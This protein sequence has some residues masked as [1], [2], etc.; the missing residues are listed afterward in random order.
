MKTVTAD[1]TGCIF[2]LL[3]GCWFL[4]NSLFLNSPQNTADF[5]PSVFPIISS[6]GIIL[7][8]VYYIVRIIIKK[9]AESNVKIGIRNRNRVL[10]AIAVI[11][12][13]ISTMELAGY[14]I[15]SAIFIPLFLF[16]AGVKGYK[17]IISVSIGFTFFVYIV[18][19]VLLGIPLP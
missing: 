5:G 8:S 13:Y 6:V 9:T 4:V 2:F 17:Q 16:A 1:I 7:A 19:D 15:S 10:I 18:F 11:L 3:I 12:G 14:Y